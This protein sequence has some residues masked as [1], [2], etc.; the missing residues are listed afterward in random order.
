MSLKLRAEGTGATP[1]V[2]HFDINVRH[3]GWERGGGPHTGGVLV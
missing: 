1:D 3:C 2:D